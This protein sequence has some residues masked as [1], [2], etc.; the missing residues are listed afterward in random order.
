[1]IISV[2][3][4]SGVGVDI[5]GMAVRSS[6]LSNICSF[7]R[8]FYICFRAV[9]TSLHFRASVSVLLLHLVVESSFT[10]ITACCVVVHMQ[11]GYKKVRFLLLTSFLLQLS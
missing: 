2:V 11:C 8:S 6:Q 7:H 1:V 5:S 3:I 10:V 4:F 9:G